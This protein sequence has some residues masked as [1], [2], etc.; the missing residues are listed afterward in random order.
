MVN[1]ETTE[2]LIVMRLRGM[3][4]AFREELQ[5]PNTDL[6]FEERF[7]LLVDREWT[8]RQERSLQRRLKT[9]KLKQ[10]QA[11]LEDIDYQASRGLDRSLVRT[12][13][14]CQWVRD[15]RNIILTGPTGIGK[16]YLACA[17]ANKTCREGFTAFY[18]RVPRLL[19]ELA[20]AHAD[21]RYFKVLHKLGK[22][23]LLV[24]DDWGFSRLKESERKDF[25]EVIEERSHQGSILIASQLPLAKWHEHLGDPTIADAV[26]DRL[27][28][29]AYKLELRG[30]SM[31]QRRSTLT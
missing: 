3:A 14:T 18:I 12:L 29:N 13:A 21:G 6:T 4:N 24:L 9:A 26:L 27:I 11:C 31:R 2:K 20:I 17:L 25:L 15:H 8:L 23:N 5:K 1:Q 10:Q 22:V 16:S 7:G 30:A 19:Q 28:Y